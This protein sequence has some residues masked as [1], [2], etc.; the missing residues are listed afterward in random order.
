[1]PFPEIRGESYMFLVYCVIQQYSD[2]IFYHGQKKNSTELLSFV[3]QGLALEL[4][5]AT[6]FLPIWQC[7]TK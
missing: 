3:T 7:W 5:D 1:M 4:V 6:L 2:I